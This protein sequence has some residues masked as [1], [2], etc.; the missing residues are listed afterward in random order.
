MGA[1]LVKLE[2]GE[3][4]RDAVGHAPGSLDQRRVL[5]DRVVRQAVGAPSD[6]GQDP[7]LGQAVKV[8]AGD[9]QPVEVSGADYSAPPCKSDNR[10]FWRLFQSGA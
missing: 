4:T 1:D 2:S 8:G 5:C 6:T 10:L 3:E 7:F 9:P